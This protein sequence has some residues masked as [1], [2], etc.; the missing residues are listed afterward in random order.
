MSKLRG[1][2]LLEC[3]HT[4]VLSFAL[5]GA[6]L[7]SPSAAASSVRGALP[8]VA[9]TVPSGQTTIDGFVELAWKVPDSPLHDLF[10]LTEQSSGE[11]RVIYV[12]DPS[13]RIFR[14]VPGRYAFRLQACAMHGDPGPVCGPMSQTLVVEVGAEILR[15]TTDAAEA[16]AGA[17]NARAGDAIAG[18]PDQMRPGLWQNPERPGHGWSFYWSNYLALARDHELHGYYYDLHGIWYTYEA[19]SRYLDGPKSCEKGGRGGECSWAFGNYRPWAARLQLIRDGA[20]SY[21]GGI[22][23]TRG[24]REVQAGSARVVFGGGNDRATIDWRMNFKY[25]S[26]AAIEEIEHL[27]G[28]QPAGA[29]NISHLG[30][31][32]QA[33]G[34][35]RYT[36]AADVGAV[37]EAFQIVFEDDLG[38]PTWVQAVNESPPAAGETSLCF[39]YVLYGYAPDAFGSVEQVALGCDATAAASATNRN[40][41]RT[42]DDF[43]RAQF[44]AGFALPPGSAGGELIVGSAASPVRLEKRAGLHRIFWREPGASCEISALRPVCTVTLDWFTDGDFPEATAFAFNQSTGSRQAVASSTEPAMRGVSVDLAVAGSWVFELRAGSTG[45]SPLIAR[46]EEL[47]VVGVAVVSP[48]SLAGEWLDSAARRFRLQWRHDLAQDIGRFELEETLPDSSIVL[49]KF[50]AGPEGL[51]ELSYPQGPYGLFSYRVRACRDGEDTEACSAWSDPLPWFVAHDGSYPG[52][53]R[54]WGENTDNSGTLRQDQDYHHAMG[55]HFRPEVDGVVL[56]LG[57]MYNG[58]NTV[59]LFERASGRLLAAAEV[60]GDNSFRY[61]AIAPV[62]VTAGTEYT[63]AVYLYEGGG[64]YYSSPWLPSTWSGVTILASTFVSLRDDPD[65]I[66]V[67][68]VD[69]PMY[70]QADIGFLPLDPAYNS[71][72]QITVPADRFNYRGDVVELAIEVSDP[73]GDAIY[74]TISGLPDGLAESSECLVSGTVTAADGDYTVSVMASDGLT[75][76]V[77]AG[78]NWRIRVA[79]GPANPETPPDPAPRPDFSIDPESASTGVTAGEFSVDPQG[80]ARYHV[81]LLTAPGAGGL[82]PAISLDYN[83]FSP[84]GIAGVGWAL[85]GLSAIERCPQ[86]AE[87]DGPSAPGTVRLAPED[88]FC[89]D[90]QRLMLVA[91]EY[92]QDGAEYRKEIDDFSR[93]V[94]RGTAGSGPQHFVVWFGDGSFAE[95]GKS[96]DSRVEARAGGDIGT[97]L[98]WAINRRQDASGNFIEYGYTESATGP[99]ELTI[100]TVRY[101]GNVRAA[102][103]PYA[104]L[105]FHYSEGRI[106]VAPSFVGGAALGRQRLLQ[107]IDSLA[108]ARA[109]DPDFQSLRSYFLSY[110]IDGFGRQVLES[111]RECSDASA[112]H[113]FGPTRFDWLKSENAIGGT[114]FPLGDLLPRN[115]RGLAVADVNGDGRPDLLPIE[116]Q[117]NRFQLSVLHAQAD[118]SFRPEGRSYAIPDNGSRDRP[119]SLLTI[120]IDA[121]GYQDILYPSPGSGSAVW[122]VRRSDG[123]GLGEEQ[124]A[125]PGCCGQSDPNVARVLDF[126]GDG[127]AD[128]LSS[129]VDPAQPGRVEL[130]VLRNAS[131]TG[132]PN[133]FDTPRAITVQ[134][135]SALFPAGPTL[136]GWQRDYDAPVFREILA[137]SPDGAIPFDFNRDGRVDLLARVSQSYRKCAGDCP[138]HAEIPQASE[139]T[140]LDFDGADASAPDGITTARVSFYLLFESDGVSHFRQSRVV[141]VGAGLDCSVFAACEPWSHVPTAERVVPVD[142]NADGLA[143]L[144]VRDAAQDWYYLLNSGDG[145]DEPEVVALSTAQPAAE[146]G[147]FADVSGDGFPE[148]IY[149]QRDGDGAA[150]W[151]VHANDLGSGFAA[152]VD[153]G[154]RHG[155]ADEGDASLLLDFTG[156][157]MLDNL[158]LD[159]RK[160]AAD[161]LTT[162]L[163]AGRNLVSGRSSEA[164]NAIVA[165]TTATGARID[166]EYR[167]L[168]DRDVYTRMHDA[169][170][171]AWGRGSAVLDLV[172]PVYVVHAVTSTS[173]ALDDAWAT[174]RTEHHY[175][176]AKL[177]AGG[178]GFLGFGETVSWDAH[179]GLRT[180]TRFRQ[181]FPLQGVAA[182]I[183][184]V[185]VGP[186]GRFGL[187]SD[188]A[189]RTP[190]DWQPSGEFAPAPVL[191]AGDV[192]LTYRLDQWRARESA[193]ARGAWWP[194]VAETL[195]RIYTLG[196][197]LQRSELENRSY[198]EFGRLTDSVTRIWSA[199]GGAPF[200]TVSTQNRYDPPVTERWI[201]SR[202]AETERVQQR[203]HSEP[204]LRRMAFVHDEET[205][206]LLSETLEPGD[207]QL[208]VVTT[209]TLDLFGNRV[210]TDVRGAGMPTRSSRSEYDALGRWPIRQTNHFGQA[211]MDVRHWDAFGNT[212]QRADI[213][214]V[215]TESAADP[216]GRLFIQWTP[217]GAWE[218]TLLRSGSGEHCPAASAFHALVDAGGAPRRQ[219]C[220]DRL[221]RRIRE[222]MAAFDGR[223]IYRDTDYDRVGRVAAVSEPYL[224][225]DTRYWTRTDYDAL[226]RPVRVQGADGNDFDYAYAGDVAGRCG[227]SSL[228]AMLSVNGLG[229]TRVEVQN[230]MGEPTEVFDDLCG[231]IHYAYDANGKLLWVTGADGASVEMRYDAA[232]RK[233]EMRDPDFGHWQ[234]RWNALGELERQLDGNGQ[235]IDFVYDAMGRLTDRLEYR[236]VAS[237]G[238]L[239]ASLIAHE[240]HAWQNS[241]QPGVSGK[242]QPESSIYQD[243]VAGELQQKLVFEYDPYGRRSAV[244]VEQGGLRFRL[245]STFDQYGRPFQ[246]FD[247]SGDFRGVRYVYNS[248]GYISKIKESRDGVQGVGYQAIHARDARGNATYASLGNGVE[249]FAEYDPASGRLAR[250]TAYDLNGVELQDLDYLFD[251]WGNLRRTVERSDGRDRTEEFG[252]DTL[253]RLVQVS[254][255]D[256]VQGPAT[257]TETL[258]LRYGPSGNILWKS[259]LGSYAYAENGA[260]PHAVAGAGGR[261]FTYDGNGNRISGMGQALEY[262]V[263]NQV[264]HIAEP[265]ASTRFVLGVG[266]GRIRRIDD[267][268]LDGQ[269]ITHYVGNTEYI[270]TPV[271]SHFRRYIGG[272]AIAEYF[273]ASGATSV[274]FLVKD[275]LGSI[276]NVTDESGSIAS[277]TWM[278]FDAFGQRRDPGNGGPLSIAVTA[279]LNALS[280]RGF[281]GHEQIDGFGLIH[282]GGRL[283]DPALGRFLQADPLVAA[284]TESQGLNRYSYVYNSP[285]SHVDPSGYFSLS[286]FVRKW[287][288]VAV[289]A[290]AAWFT[291]GASWT[292]TAGA[293]ASGAAGSAAF[294]QMVGTVGWQTLAGT[295][296]GASA[297]F[298]AGAIMSGRLR[299]AV[300]GSFAGAITGGIGGYYGDNYS[301]GRVASETFGGGISAR[302]LGADFEDGLRLALIV[303]GLNYAN[304]RMDLSERHNSAQ[305][306]DNLNK[307]GSGLYGHRYSIAGAR[308][309]VDPQSR[310]GT[311]LTCRSPAGG[312]QGLPIPGTHDQ[313]SN[314]LG[315]AYDGQGLLSYLVDTFAGP[316][317]WFRNHV[318]RSYIQVANPALFQVVGNGRYFSGFRA[319][320]DNM[321]NFALIPAA[322]PFSMAAFVATQPFLNSTAQQWAHG[323]WNE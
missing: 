177:Q 225:G 185:A 72:P 28:P 200:L 321:A 293:V 218:R 196:G 288:R 127:L 47:D 294:A 121:D 26:L 191:P 152:A 169:A 97:A 157:G 17:E 227:V 167:P 248:Y 232:G 181:D 110:G 3:L 76:A 234:Y 214:D 323:Y 16:R 104:E 172:A 129:R 168:T 11:T 243:M 94:S 165:I 142:V 49:R 15:E 59:K 237:L 296:A 111:I 229:Q 239:D 13:L 83:H 159:F 291:Y 32:W 155:N 205:G 117:R 299:G 211:T 103:R 283:Y 190:P 189:S 230:P 20:G 286:R 260:G 226:G 93:I 223:F 264:V 213:D 52:V 265:G 173:P 131:R 206:L 217:T 182:E 201:L 252:Y 174:R 5:G 38:D 268:G 308:R 43:E 297:G 253:N 195:E 302:I 55:Y 128:L 151:T 92:G 64:S 136:G 187:L 203:N 19:Q 101:A 22:Y 235:A 81:P 137:R 126:D 139:S 39:Y 250:L 281:T 277:A 160:G 65:G 256:P 298:V 271:G 163:Y 199:D 259:D 75:A 36:V 156:D 31:L 245:A 254:L 322:A 68:N 61:A 51:V 14:A 71:A 188:P 280:G 122:V 1:F 207:P 300:K 184:V 66:P 282:M 219:H 40:G 106:D 197:K 305:N 209:Y 262:S 37:S 149:P 33:P 304:Y 138:P 62:A 67:R 276:H 21:V 320:L 314:L 12:L 27:A 132:G 80:A 231:R 141:A 212:L 148:F 251:V 267:N 56:E 316:H 221:G 154:I 285:L 116:E 150:R 273:P 278:A 307:P 222:V 96:Q 82:A 123:S 192:P 34:D 60:T 266:N 118:G 18:G 279:Q 109:D 270:E 303:S 120:D 175:A 220:F 162:G 183:S 240:A 90:G 69:F 186:A 244:T 130:V 144:A 112:E 176:G 46:S 224:A 2:K 9:W 44:W 48:H 100:D 309:I 290:I 91:G 319:I 178:R 84:N 50:P 30:G 238:D 179:R 215:V 35:A 124:I 125:V 145:F 249:A 85:R 171:A 194:Y 241:I 158:F 204:V 247:A 119:V 135:S 295:V 255:S 108:R 246:E 315:F 95:Y 180:N 147:R 99:L 153:S 63:V 313:A 89:L 318:S 306:P 7:I 4:V 258:A 242:G 25:Q 98:T 202:L 210:R 86:T 287:G 8:T 58:V 87:Q 102:T 77:P 263:S 54:I 312:C 193:A 29:E 70:G 133:L 114:G 166:L 79:N 113:C 73:D 261:E 107:R 289:A 269:R 284:P 216:M 301:L 143:D 228:N 57:G 275:H 115:F 88:R 140:E 317:D 164:I 233:T 236:G 292:W 24:G 53:R 78:F 6:L 274:N 134:Y 170:A 257:P 310:V 23:V 10:R 41:G 42:F 161:D 74:C 311:Y 45:E 198:T 208:E 272:V 146:H 105:R